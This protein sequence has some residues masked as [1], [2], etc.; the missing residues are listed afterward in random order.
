[1]RILA[2]LCLFFWTGGVLRAQVIAHLT[3]DQHAVFNLADK[4]VRRYASMLPEFM[5]VQTTCSYTDK[6]GLDPNWKRDRCVEEEVLF[7]GGRESYRLIGV[8]SR[9]VRPKD[10][11][12][13]STSVIEY[14]AIIMCIFEQNGAMKSHPEI[15]WERLEMPG[16]RKLCVFSYRIPEERSPMSYGNRVGFHGLISVD[17]STGEVVRIENEWEPNSRKPNF[18]ARRTI[19]EYGL[20]PIGKRQY[21]LPIKMWNYLKTD[22]KLTRRETTVTQYRK[23]FVDT[24]MTIET[25]VNPDKH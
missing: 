24:E 16:N 20:V 17:Q 1:M 14:E 10:L 22:K 2:V 8:N 5:A 15:G 12:S 9:P 7:H 19:L 4:Y 21:M 25:P 6:D 18:R 11:K 3:E 13:G 23:F